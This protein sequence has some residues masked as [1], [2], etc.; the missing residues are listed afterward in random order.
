MAYVTLIESK[1]IN[2]F[3]YYCRKLFNSTVGFLLTNEPTTDPYFIES[4]TAET[5]SHSEQQF[6]FFF[7]QQWGHHA[8]T[9]LKIVC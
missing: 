5:D 1:R 3:L 4:V 9:I 2:I 6:R 7:K 8:F